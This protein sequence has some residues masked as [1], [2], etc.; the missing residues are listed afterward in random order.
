MGDGANI[1]YADGLISTA[2]NRS[3]RSGNIKLSRSQYNL[4]I[5]NIDKIYL[6]FSTDYR[7]FLSE[8]IDDPLHSGRSHYD[9]QIYSSI[10]LS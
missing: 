3:F 4:D 7:N 5:L 2:Q 10:I 9:Y 6:S 8:S 1:S